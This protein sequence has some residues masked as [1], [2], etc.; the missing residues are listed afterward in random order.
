MKKQQKL[1]IGYTLCNR[2]RHHEDFVSTITKFIDKNKH[3]VIVIDESDAT[4]KRLG[5]NGRVVFDGI[6]NKSK[7]KDIQYVTS[8]DEEV[9]VNYIHSNAITT[10]EV[11][12]H[13][14]NE[15]NLKFPQGESERYKHHRMITS[16]V[17]NN[18]LK[19][20]LKLNG[21]NIIAQHNSAF[22]RPFTRVKQSEDGMRKL[23]ELQ[24]KEK[25]KLSLLIRDQNTMIPGEGKYE[26]YL[27]YKHKIECLTDKANRKYRLDYLESDT[28]GLNKLAYVLYK[29]KVWAV[30][31]KIIKLAD[32]IE[33]ICIKKG[34]KEKYNLNIT[35]NHI[36]ID[37]M[38]HG[39]VYIEIERINQ[40]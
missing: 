26:R 25:D 36:E 9:G 28:G 2:G 13:Q 6:I 16:L 35:P 32:K 5:L 10:E 29:Y 18:E 33:S 40:S 14:I 21:L 3:F 11:E 8:Q 17:F 30:V 15:H 34:I 38:D 12:W 20:M 39:M 22:L 31:E 7:R 27:R 37:N 1:I 23:T 4:D 24:N 19:E